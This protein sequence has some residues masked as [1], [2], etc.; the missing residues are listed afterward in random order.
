MAREMKST[1]APS[2]NPFRLGGVDLPMPLILVAKLLAACLLARLLWRDL[3]DPFLP[4]VPFLDSFRNAPY[5]GWALRGA[6]LIGAVA[7]LLNY[8][9]RAACLLIGSAFLLGTLSSRIYFENNRMFLGCVFFLLGLYERRTGPW[10]VR[11]QV[12]LVFFS[13]ALNKLLN[14][15]WRSGHFFDYWS[16]FAI[17]KQMYFQLASLLPQMFLPRFMSWMTITMEFSIAFG[18]LF[19]RTRPWAIWTGLLLALGMNVLTERTFGVFFYAMPICYLA[20]IEWPRS[21]ITVLYDGDC[22]FCA[23]T[24][25]WM[26]RFDLENLFAW[27]PFQQAR[28]LYGISKEALRQRLYVVA[29]GKKYSGFRA[30]KMM[31]LYNPL[32]YFFMLA[33]LM[34]PQSAYLHHRSWVAVFFVLFFSPLFVPVGETAYA[35]IASNRHRILSGETCTVETP[36]HSENRGLHV[37]RPTWQPP[38]DPGISKHH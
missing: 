17:N 18:L 6:A 33:A 37:G 29:E 38:L 30:F 16:H 11:I 24:R 34:L 32:T 13:A 19:R 4:M 27:Q 15:S 12:M 14:V 3:P 5:F 2:R 35:W 10:L 25:R 31:A 28:D 26:E 36:I 1:V 8:R 7:V 9:L 22:G 21:T 23:R 20:F